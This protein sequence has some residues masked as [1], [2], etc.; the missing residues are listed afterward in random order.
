MSCAC[1]LKPRT[2]LHRSMPVFLTRGTHACH[3]SL[4]PKQRL[5]LAFCLRSATRHPPPPYT[6]LFISLA[7]PCLPPSLWQSLSC[8]ACASPEHSAMLYLSHLGGEGERG[9]RR[10]YDSICAGDP[11]P[12][13]HHLPRYTQLEAAGVICTLSP[14]EIHCLQ[15]LRAPLLPAPA[16][17]A[18]WWE[19]KKT[20]KHGC[21]GVVQTEGRAEKKH[22]GRKEAPPLPACTTTLPPTPLWPPL[23]HQLLHARTRSMCILNKHN[24]LCLFIKPVCHFYNAAISW[25]SSST[26]PIFYTPPHTC[27]LFHGTAL[28]PPAPW[29]EPLVSFLLRRRRSGGQYD[30]MHYPHPTTSVL[31][32][33][34]LFS[35]PRR[36]GRINYS[37]SYSNASRQAGVKKGLPTFSIASP[38]SLRREGGRRRRRW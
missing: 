10:R 23:W 13:K 4:P 27:P 12:A 21:G 26:P 2:T 34:H 32:T 14:L 33:C 18:A 37:L 7:M 24:T 3:P 20:I 35:W 15:P 11:P 9:G 30:N 1:A 16:L 5:H 22:A 36:Q 29:K 19:G 8:K 38:S 28:Y 31:H 6:S 17:L 25:H